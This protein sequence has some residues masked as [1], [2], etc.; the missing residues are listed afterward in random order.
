MT[1][2]EDTAE[3][4][5]RTVKLALDMGDA[6]TIEDAERIFSGYRMQL[7]LGP[8]VAGNPVMQVAALTAVN[9]AARTLLGGVRIVGASGN[10]LV[11][12]PSYA[13]FASALAGLGG[14]LAAAA[15]PGWPTLVIGT[16]DTGEIEP[17]ALR[18]TF[19]GWAGGVVPSASNRRLDETGMFTPAGVLA[20]ALGVSEIFQRLRGGNVMACRRAIGLNL[21]QPDKDWLVPGEGAALSRLPS[22][23]WLVGLG[24]LGQAYLWTLGF[25]PYGGNTAEL[26]LQDF[27]FLAQS[28]LSTSLLTTPDLLGRR[29]TRAMAEWA[30]A[31]GFRVSIVERRFEPDFRVSDKEPPV[32][33]VGVDNAL[34]R[35]GIEEVGFGRIIEAGLGRGPQDYLGIDVHT[36]PASKPAR[37]IWQETEAANVE[38]GQPAYQLLLERTGDRCGTVRLA[39]RSIGAPFAGAVAAALVVAE[40][41]RLSLGAEKYELVSCHLRDLATRSVIR[42]QAWE[43]FNPGVF[44]VSY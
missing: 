37:E 23:A 35:Q 28:N 5:H 7:I 44:S 10:L 36:F 2:L 19:S 33:L 14:N 32:A 31:R 42:G 30:E 3:R 13:D 20:G 29:K 6:A 26:V 9:C 11:N 39:G 40:F 21:W 8:E 34:A 38:I 24:N 43:A 27:D 25:L 17:L 4:L 16:G 1:V 18:A 22:S 41:L 15:E 12:F